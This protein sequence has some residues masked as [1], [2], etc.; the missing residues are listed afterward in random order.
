[1][2]YDKHGKIDWLK[3]IG[4]LGNT[5]FKMLDLTVKQPVQS[6]GQ[7]GK[8][9]IT[10]FHNYHPKY[11]YIPWRGP[12]GDITDSPPFY[13]WQYTLSHSLSIGYLIEYEG[14]RIYFSDSPF[15]TSPKR[16]GPVDIL[17]QTIA[18]REV[19]N[20]IAECLSIMKPCHYIPAHYDNFFKPLRDMTSFDPIIGVE[21]SKNVI[22]SEG[23][24]LVDFSR[25]APFLKEFNDLYN[26]D[27]HAKLRLLKLLTYYSLDNLVQ[28]N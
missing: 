9:N 6:V 13:S 1:M 4:G 24:P 22:N 19:E 28:K 16:I 21:I 20:N 15:I 5:Q 18:V 11:N 17:I 23:V 10:A 27:K 7:F 8:F 14:L 3:R 26:Q 12:S 2:A 25:F